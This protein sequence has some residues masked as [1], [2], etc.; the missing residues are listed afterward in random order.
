MTTPRPTRTLTTAEATEAATLLT[1]WATAL[2]YLG[3]GHGDA[4]SKADRL[5]DLHFAARHLKAMGFVL[6]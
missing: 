2:D 6:D 5:A 1:M 4:E 3:T